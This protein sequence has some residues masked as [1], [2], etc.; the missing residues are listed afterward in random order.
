VVANFFTVRLKG[1]R[2]LFLLAGVG[3][4]ENG[5]AVL[6]A[7]VFVLGDH[8]IGVEVIKE[9][10]SGRELGFFLRERFALRLGGNFIEDGDEPG[11]ERVEVLPVLLFSQVLVVE[12]LVRLVED[13]I[14]VE[15]DLLRVL[16]AL[17]LQATSDSISVGD[18]FSSSVSRVKSRRGLT[19]EKSIL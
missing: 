6:Q 15:R 3:E 7:E 4:D 12:F 11:D 14:E 9:V 19:A 13:G 17:F 5:A 10:S 8:L 1:R 18:F 16:L 2:N